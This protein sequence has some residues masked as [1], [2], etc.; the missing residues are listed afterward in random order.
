MEATNESFV[1]CKFSNLIVTKNK[2]SLCS[3]KLILKN[4]GLSYFGFFEFVVYIF[5]AL[6]FVTGVYSIYHII[7]LVNADACGF[8]NEANKAR[9]CGARWIHMFSRAQLKQINF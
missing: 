6:L 3:S 2:V 9:V 5:V 7:E 1:K 8:K 4:I